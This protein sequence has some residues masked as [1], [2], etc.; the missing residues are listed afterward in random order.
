MSALG[1]AE[2]RT[3]DIEAKDAEEDREEVRSEPAARKRTGRRPGNTDSRRQILEAAQEKFA[4]LGYEGASIRSIA[5]EA[6]VDTALIHHFYVSK[7]RLFI[8][9][10]HDAVNPD[11]IVASVAGRRRALR[12]LGERLTRT[13]L[14]LWENESTRNQMRGIMRS[15]VT[16]EG[17]AQL[18]RRYFIEQVSLPIAESTGKSHPEVRAVLATSV[19]LGM[20][21]TRYI[22]QVEPID[23]MSSDDLVACVAPVLQ[24][25]FTGPLPMSPT[26]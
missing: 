7:E 23:T 17:A 26:D 19:L 21:M 5:Q 25:Y 8:A 16:H 18:L 15:A 1:R 12:G 4:Q 22:V 11:Q 13:Y 3:E 6:G 2:V 9:A 14:G 20:A 10:V 24:R